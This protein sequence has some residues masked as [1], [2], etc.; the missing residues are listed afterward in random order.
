MDPPRQHARTGA[1]DVALHGFVI[2]LETGDEVVGTYGGWRR[3]HLLVAAGRQARLSISWARHAA[4]PDLSRTLRAAGRRSGPGQVAGLQV[5]DE[6]IDG[7]ARLGSWDSPQGAFH[8]AVR[9][10]PAAGLTLVVRQLAPGGSAEMRTL[11]AAVHGVASDQA[12]PWRIY[13]L[14]LELPPSWRLEGLQQLAG[15]VRAVWFRYPGRA[16]RPDQLLVMRRLACASRL[17]ASSSLGDWVRSG[18][19]RREQ[20]TGSSEDGGL[21]HL[22]T[23]LPAGSWWRRLRGKSDR[24]ELYAWTVAEGDRLVLQEWKGAADPLPCL[25]GA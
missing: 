1:A 16:L 10:L 6:A 7:H 19:S 11:I 23:T 15:L 13:G 24:R 3:G 22:S 18:L 12:A 5:A 21:V 17:L 8:A 2:P 14:D 9:H 4:A 20:L 25:R